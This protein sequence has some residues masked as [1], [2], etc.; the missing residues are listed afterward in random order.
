MR[1][2][3]AMLLSL[4]MTLSLLTSCEMFVPAP[5]ESSRPNFGLPAGDMLYYADKATGISGPLCGRPECTHDNT[6]CNT[7]MGVP[8]FTW[9]LTDYDGRLY[10]VGKDDG[11]IK[12]V[13]SAAYDGTDHREIRKLDD[14][15]LGH[16]W[17]NSYVLFHRGC[18][19]WSYLYN[20]VVD[21]EAKELARVIAF[22]LDGDQ[23]GYVV[24]E[25]EIHGNY[26]QILP[27]RNSL[28][29]VISNESGSTADQE[30]I[31][32][33]WNIKTGEGE[34]LYHGR[35]PLGMGGLMLLVKD[36]EGQTVLDKTFEGVEWYNS[37]VGASTPSCIGVD[38]T[39]M[40]FRSDISSRNVYY[41]AV[42]LD[43]GELRLLWSSGAENS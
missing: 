17:N 3:F 7:Y 22:P 24:L 4:M 10:W 18:L 32:Y 19:Y 9:E 30:N 40:Y 29:I 28:Y 13:Y 37:A 31:I 2:L 1:R 25:T 35:F 6:D 20:E 43:G 42:P 5:S 11:I 39:Y 14:D 23:E 34:E 16:E 26:V 15:I 36:F 8:H 41:A 12:R 27:C 21:G 33:R 38:D